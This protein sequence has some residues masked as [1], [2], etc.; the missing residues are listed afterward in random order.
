MNKYSIKDRL[1]RFWAILQYSHLTTI[2]YFTCEDT[3]MYHIFIERKLTK[4]SK[5]IYFLNLRQRYL[6]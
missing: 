3:H 4:K 6:T 1:L 2:I 5:I